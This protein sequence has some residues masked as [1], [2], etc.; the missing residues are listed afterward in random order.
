MVE[1]ANVFAGEEPGSNSELGQVPAVWLWAGDCSC[2]SES[3][4]IK[5][6]GPGT[7]LLETKECVEST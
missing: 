3:L 4:S 7:D 2:A 6:E 1:R 5:T